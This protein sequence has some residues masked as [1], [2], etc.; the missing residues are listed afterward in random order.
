MK[1]SRLT[2]TTRSID[3]NVK[4]PIYVE[5]RADKAGIADDER[6]FVFQDSHGAT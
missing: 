1:P 6:H 4:A 2:A 3:S 5:R